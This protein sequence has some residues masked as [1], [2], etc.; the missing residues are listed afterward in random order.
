M[1]RWFGRGGDAVKVMM[2]I[3]TD[4]TTHYNS[5]PFGEEDH[6]INPSG[7]DLGRIDSTRIDLTFNF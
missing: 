6:R 4:K 3:W 7:I 2:V 5:L 1:W